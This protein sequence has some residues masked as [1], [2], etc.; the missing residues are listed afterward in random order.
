MLTL[1]F[2]RRYLFSKKS[3]SVI[4]LISGVSVVAVSLPVAA[5][6]ILLS[7]FNGFEGLIRSMASAFDADL[8]ITPRRGVLFERENLDTAPLVSLE[9]VEAFGFVVEQK[10]L[11]RHGEQQQQVT[12]RGVEEG[13]EELFPIREA[14]VRGHYRVEEPESRQIVMGRTMS[15]LLGLRGLNEEAVSLYALKRSNFSSL[16]PLDGYTRREAK[17]AGLFSLDARSEEE[18]ILCSRSLVDELFGTEGKASALLLKVEGEPEALRDKVQ[19]VVG[20]E[21]RV[22][23]RYELRP[24]FYDIMTYEKWGIFFIALLILALASFSMVGSLVMLILEKRDETET[25][26]AMGADTKF[27]RRIFLYEGALIALLG[28]LL[29]LVPGIGITLIQQHFGVIKLPVE[30][31]IVESYP[32][33]FRWGDLVATLLGFALITGLVSFST[34]RSM[35]RPKTHTEKRREL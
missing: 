32:V 27:I 34:V 13:Y 14:L 35:I 3:H 15:Y 29:G 25:L 20:E 1:R 28:A 9:G 21:F 24:T 18:Y 12:L 33:E 31:F 17:V 5:M 6:I 7:V 4:N 23:T 19:E 8:S 2:A 16:L 11:V 10:G 30:S 22:R 26:R